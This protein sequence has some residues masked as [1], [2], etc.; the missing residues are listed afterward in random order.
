RRRT[1]SSS[2]SRPSCP[3]STRCSSTRCRSRCTAA[4]S[5]G[6]R[7]RAS[8]APATSSLPV[9]PP[10]NRRHRSWCRRSVKR[11]LIVAATAAAL[12]LPAVASAWEGVSVEVTFPARVVAGHVSTLDFHVSLG[13]KPLDLATVGRRLPGLRPVV[14]FTKG[15]R[16]VTATPTARTGVDRVRVV[17]PSIRGW[18]YRFEYAGL[19]RSFT[20]GAAPGR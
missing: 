9:H 17:L 8:I 3:T 11:L 4:A 12:L 13:G 5:E 18:T 19:E 6:A 7:R 15:T 20:L 1:R 10:W 2:G 14:V 16:H